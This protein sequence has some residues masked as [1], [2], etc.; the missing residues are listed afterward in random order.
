MAAPDLPAR[1]A[2]ALW[3]AWFRNFAAQA[4]L[5][6]IPWKILWKTIVARCAEWSEA[7]AGRLALWTPVAIGAGAALYL[8]LNNEPPVW[9]GPLLLLAAGGAAYAFSARRRFALALFLIA[10]G[11]TAADFRASRVA[12]P[13]LAREMTPK[14]IEGRLLSVEEGPGGRRLLVEASSV[15]RL[16]KAATPKRVR[17]VWRGE[18]FD[19][20]PGDRIA[21]RAGL[22]PPPPPSAPGGFDFARQLYFQR[23]GAV[24]Y[25]VTP[26]R[27]IAGP[28]HGPGARLA[29]AIED[30]RLALARRIEAAAPGAGGGIVAAVV[31]GKRGR[32][33][34]AA[35]ATLRDSGLAHLLA[36]SGLHMGLATGLIFFAL[37]LALAAIEPLALRFPIKK[38]AAGA[39]LVSGFAYLL[40]SG[41]GWSA[42]R[43]FIMYSI[44]FAA[45]LADRRALS[46]RNVAI[47][48]IIILLLTPEAV[49]HPGFQMSFAA[50]TALIAAYEWG[51]RRADPGR[52]FAWPARLR[53]YVFGIAVTDTIAAT[54]TAPFALYHFNRAASFG[55]AANIVSVPIM[56]FWVMPAAIL[57]LLLMPFGLDA[58]A[59]RLSAAG[60][61]AI[62]A[63]G[64]WVASLPGDI[65]TVR[66]WP[67][68]ALGVLTLGGLWL[69]LQIR[70]WRLAGLAAIPV[71]A[72]LIALTPASALF[73]SGDGL[74][75]GVV[76]QGE[77]G[78]RALALFN[79]R[80][81]RFA[82][83]VWKEHA[84]LDRDRAATLALADIGRCDKA[85]CV[86]V[87]EG[88]TVAVSTDP[89]GLAEDCARAGL[90]IALYPLP[91][92][93]PPDCAAPI[94]D[95]G[96]VWSRGA[97]AASFEGEKIRIETV[98]QFRGRRPWTE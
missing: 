98:S 53:R 96:L 20:S 90:V 97:H 61:D 55:L 10:L 51:G 38:W 71:A 25:A 73:V 76:T 22:S 33:S 41:G 63:V 77:D 64:G 45:I 16:D 39:A 88:E 12:A 83:R 70:P 5:W 40:L 78:A 92:F 15:E 87:V 35:E 1:P 75:V 7:E 44:M 52:S 79:P 65:I 47:A 48:A 95:R 59:W 24:G 82:A 42:Q 43:A 72:V 28:E 46:L 60:V 32:V 86:V 11:F 19:V 34:E 4:R 8:G 2:R 36:I 91:K 50:V 6:K 54:A 62:L 21:F 80:K 84:G 68:A 74:N 13:M 17:V 56:G 30:A 89:L 23:I 58:W 27:R 67:T 57:A 3:G 18:G 66:H 85:G 37:R 26:P 81:D 94:I 93:H 29:E 9:A 14:D 49:V 31:T 69:C